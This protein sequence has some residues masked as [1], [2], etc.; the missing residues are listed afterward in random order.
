MYSISQVVQQF[1]QRWT[2]QLDDQLI[3]EVCRQHG[4]TW[5][6]RILTPVFTVQLFLLQILWGN[7]ACDHLPRLTGRRFT[8]EA[9]CKARSKL[10]LAVLQE[11]LTRITS[12]MLQASDATSL[13][14]GHRLWLMDG[15]GLSMPDTPELQRHFG[16]PGGQ[17]TGCG[18]PVAHCVALVHA[19]TGLVQ[20]LITAPLRT[21]DMALAWQLD[22]AMRAGDVLVADRAYSSYAHL[23]LLFQRGVQSVMRAHPRLRIDF[24]ARRPHAPPGKPRTG[25]ERGR[26]YSRWVRRLGKRDQV[27]E[28]YR[29]KSCPTWLT[30][31]QFAALPMSLLVRELRYK[32][33]RRGYRTRE[34]TLVTTLLDHKRYSAAE[35][36]D[37]YRQRW[38]IETD[39]KHLKITLR[40]DVLKCRTVAGVEKE[41]VMFVLVY[42]LVRMVMHA[43][44]RRQQVPPARISFLDTLRWLL[45]ATPDSR[46]PELIVN[47][48]RPHRCEPRVRKRRPKQ[49]PVMKRPRSE[50]RKALKNTVIGA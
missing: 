38:R 4:H 8:G 50:L 24:T 15:T 44:A 37:L 36:A 26:P 42:N 12:A 45:S 46:L 9:Y 3:E 11:L 32:I 7:T 19:A 43:A 21:H 18:F 27:V 17:R 1:K 48:C 25:A 13:W 49:Y 33:T 2:Q 31:E 39:F 30:A 41:A 22:Q 28:W 35:L 20:R 23:S 10:P 14:H 29:P 34:V 16:Q 40:M 5:R 6:E 47:P